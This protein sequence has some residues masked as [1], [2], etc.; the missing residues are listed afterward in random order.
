MDKI[1]KSL[2]EVQTIYTKK[3]V[4]KSNNKLLDIDSLMK[5]I[6]GQVTIIMHTANNENESK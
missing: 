4:E 3:A 6:T 5:N 2:E 1:I